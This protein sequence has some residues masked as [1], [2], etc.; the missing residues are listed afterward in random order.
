ML[1]TIAPTVSAHQSNT[2][3]SLPG[4]KLWWISSVMPHT[5]TIIMG[6]A[7]RH[8]VG[9]FVPTANATQNASTAKQMQCTSLS[10]FQKVGICS[11]VSCEERYQLHPKMKSAGNQ[12]RIFFRR[13][14]R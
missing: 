14:M 10:A 4:V 6:S 5:E 8:C 11:I 1:P 12:R 7:I 2:D 3:D 9:N 13:F